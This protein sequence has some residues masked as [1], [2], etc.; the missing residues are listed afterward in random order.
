MCSHDASGTVV[1]II[2]GIVLRIVIGIVVETVVGTVVGS[3]P[4]FVAKIG[5]VTV[6]DTATI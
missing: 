4:F 5:T 2:V 3:S 1:G 6:I